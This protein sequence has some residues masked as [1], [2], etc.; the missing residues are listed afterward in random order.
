MFKNEASFSFSKATMIAECPLKYYRWTY[1]S[2]GG[3]W[4]G[5]KPPSD[6]TAEENYEAKFIETIPSWSGKIIHKAAQ[7]ILDQARQG[8]K[9]SDIEPVMLAHA[10]SMFA[11]GQDQ[12]LNQHSGNPK[13]RLQLSEIIDG[14]PV[15]WENVWLRI[16]QKLHSLAKDNSWYKAD[17]GNETRNILRHAINNYRQIVMVE[18]L[19]S[20]RRS[21]LRVWVAMD[22]VIRGSDNSVIVVDWKTGR[23]RKKDKLQAKLYGMWANGLGWSSVHSV[24]PYISQENVQ[25]DHFRIT[26]EDI[27]KTG[28]IIDLFAEDLA[29]RLKDG[30]LDQNIPIRDKFEATDDPSVCERC[31]FYRLCKRD[32][33][34]P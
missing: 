30:D 19:M 9:F 7:H 25:V 5:N 3:W 27:E 1:A 28:M 8:R 31:P 14:E 6:R 33:T 20:F 29:D 22:L 34:K 16:Q 32:G 26:D 11:R 4:R 23:K 18:D 13:H 12:A 24:I 17:T 15:N 10:R 21:G 2:W